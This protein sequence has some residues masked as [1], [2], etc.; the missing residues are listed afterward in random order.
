[1]NAL[2]KLSR[3][4]LKIT[5][6]ALLD[7]EMDDPIGYEK[8][9]PEGDNTGN[10]RKTLKGEQGAIEI[11]TSRDRNGSLGPVLVAKN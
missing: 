4:L 5:V 11:A 10:S 1:M 2:D 3:E 7:T 8:H 6:E 9:S